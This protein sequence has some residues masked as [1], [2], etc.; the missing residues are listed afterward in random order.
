MKFTQLTANAAYDF[1]IM[2]L[3]NLS[4]WTLNKFSMFAGQVNWTAWTTSSQNPNIIEW[5]FER[6]KSTSLKQIQHVHMANWKAWA[7]GS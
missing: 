4:S 5:F 2:E 7:T 1:N 6:P 3:T